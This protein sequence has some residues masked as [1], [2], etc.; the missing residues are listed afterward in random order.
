[1]IVAKAPS[2]PLARA[3]SRG[4]AQTPEGAVA[5]FVR[6]KADLWQLSAD[7]AA[8]IE[9]VSV[10][11]PRG[12]APP[13]ASRGGARSAARSSF[14]LGNLKT[15]NLVQRVEG[16]EVFN[17]DMTAAVN[18]NNEV[19]TVAG[20]F[21]P[22]AASRSTRARALGV[23]EPRR[24]AADAAGG[25]DRP[26]RV[27]PDQ[28]RRTPPR[29]SAATPIRPTAAPYRFYDYRAGRGTIRV[30]RSSGRCASRT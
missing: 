14:S 4:A 23:V 17:S 30:R 8:T 21:F 28:R 20:Q 26:R 27:R 18:A 1:M 6:S 19:I 7:D 15:V 16:K 29:T 3:A 13:P 10:S 5:E 11:A 24:A 9:V 12:A 22:G 2:A 25:S